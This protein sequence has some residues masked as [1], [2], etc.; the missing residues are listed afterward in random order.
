MA[1]DGS[2]STEMVGTLDTAV[3]KMRPGSTKAPQG[4][5]IGLPSE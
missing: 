2:E 4:A 1:Y 5:L 3:E